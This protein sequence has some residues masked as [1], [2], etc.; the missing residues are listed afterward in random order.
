MTID[1]A[2][3]GA[4]LTCAAAAGAGAEGAVVVVAGVEEVVP[5]KDGTAGAVPAGLAVAPRFPKRDAEAGLGAVGASAFLPA[6]SVAAGGAPVV[7][8]DKE[9]KPVPAFGASLGVEEPAAEAVSFAD[10][11]GFGAPNPANRPPAA[12]GG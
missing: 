4:A 10:S 9:N 1:G 2:G 6:S 3:S 8:E 5:S 11:A 7:A 12:A